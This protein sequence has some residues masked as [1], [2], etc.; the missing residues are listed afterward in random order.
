MKNSEDKSEHPNRLDRNRA[1]LLGRDLLEMNDWVILSCK[2]STLQGG[3]QPGDATHL[4]SIS[5]IGPGDRALMDVLV[6]PNGAVNSELLK[7]HGCDSAHTFNAPPF[8]GV[9]KILQAGF[10]RTRVIAW[11]PEKVKSALSRLCES[12]ELPALSTVYL[13]LQTHYTAFVGEIDPYSNGAAYK[14]VTLPPQTDC[15]TAGVTPLTESRYLLTLIQEMAASS[16]NTEAAA[17]DKNWSAAF[18]KPKLGPTQKL[19]ELLGLDNNQS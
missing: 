4:V 2:E 12:T 7:L 6:R 11:N 10:A 13:D 15:S 3:A 18:Y 8:S 1:I 19:K 16:Q 14:K 17:F 9:H 5:V